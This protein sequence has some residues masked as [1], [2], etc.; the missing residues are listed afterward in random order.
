MVT[1]REKKPLVDTRGTQTRHYD[2]K[3]TIL[4]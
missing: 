3:E 4:K 1:G 2:S